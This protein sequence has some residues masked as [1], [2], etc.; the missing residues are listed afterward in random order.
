M[1]DIKRLKA[2]DEVLRTQPQAKENFVVCDLP[3]F[4]EFADR[5]P[6]KERTVSVE[7][8]EWWGGMSYA[9]SL[10]A[11]RNGNEAAVAESDRLLSDMET[12]VPVSRSWRMMNSVIGTCPDVP[13]YL[14]GNPYNM[15]L[16]RRVTSATAPLSIFVELVASGGVDTA[17]CLKRG[18]AMLALVRMLAT[19]RPVELW[20]VIAIGRRRSR[21]SLCVRLD[22]TPLDLARSAHVFT[23]PSVFRALGYKSLEHDFYA[24]IRTCRCGLQPRQRRAGGAEAGRRTHGPDEPPGRS[25]PPGQRRRPVS[26]VHSDVAF[27]MIPMRGRGKP[28]CLPDT[29]RAQWRT[30]IWMKKA[31]GLLQ[32]RCNVSTCRQFQND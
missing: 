16:R 12:L 21:S 32:P 26:W 11:L 1:L 19:V 13:Q 10:Q 4:A 18:A 27:G 5:V 25:I 9:Q 31:V 6:V 20:C 30:H 24:H 28:P 8:K 7:R 23:H 2:T 17:T 14:A 15:R 22:T 3:G 29:H